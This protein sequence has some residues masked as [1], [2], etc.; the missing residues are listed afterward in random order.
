MH[1][2]VKPLA[3]SISSHGNFHLEPL[4][5]TSALFRKIFNV[6]GDR[7]LKNCVSNRTKEYIDIRFY[8]KEKRERTKLFHSLLQVANIIRI[9]TKTTTFGRHIDIAGDTAKSCTKIE[10]GTSNNQHDPDKNSHNVEKMNSELCKNIFS[11]IG[12]RKKRA[13]CAK[14]KEILAIITKLE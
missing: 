5:H 4:C 2:T 9:T 3:I 8:S 14:L 1:V 12:G 13:D 10:S 7:Y 11:C 6:G